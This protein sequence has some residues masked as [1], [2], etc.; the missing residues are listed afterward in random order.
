MELNRDEFGAL[1][2]DNIK[3]GKYTDKHYIFNYKN[4]R[5]YLKRCINI[6]NIYNGLIAE[7]I[8]HDFGISCTH[9]D[10]YVDD[11]YYGYISKEIN[12]NYK[13]KAID[14]YLN[15]DK[16]NN[17]TD[18]WNIFS[19]NDNIM[20][21]FVNVF[22]FDV[23]IA[24]P[25]RHSLNLTIYNDEEIGMLYD[26]ENMLNED[27]YL[28]GFYSLQIDS[29]DYSMEIGEYNLL[30]KFL[31]RSDNLY[32]EILKSKLWIISEENLKSVFKRVEN[33]LGV[34]MQES[35]KNKIIYKMKLNYDKIN[36]VI[37]KYDRVNGYEYKFKL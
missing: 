3:F 29:D 1:I 21:S 24:N 6:E 4:E 11:G 5:Y 18:I 2:I 20:C 13:C 26:N 34:S 31:Y 15:E 12:N 9:S 16:N 27:S 7:F 17:L 28:Y 30:E 10:I 8:A 19:G 33:R 25:D 37:K 14:E 36:E 22:L 35:I 32:L 23:L